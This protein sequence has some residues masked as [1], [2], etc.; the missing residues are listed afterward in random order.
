MHSPLHLP[1]AGRGRRLGPAAAALLSAALL[2][3]LLAAP[4]PHALAQ[5]GADP[6]VQAREAWRVKDRVR[7]AALRDAAL[8]AGQPLAMWV[9]YFDL[10]ARLADLQQPEFEA[11]AARWPGTYVE[12]R[13]RNDWLLELGKRR[14]WGNFRVEFP[15]FRMNDDREVSCY[16]MLLQHQDGQDVRSAAKA[17]WYAQRDADNGCQLLG[18]T[19]YDARVLNAADIWQEVRLSVEFNRPRAAAAAVALLDPAHA[20]RLDAVFKDPGRLLRTRRDAES[21]TSERFQVLALWRLA[22]SDPDAAFTQMEQHYAI[23]LSHAEA[24]HAWAGIAKQSALKLQ[25]RADDYARRAWRSWERSG[26]AGAAPPWSDDMLAW[27]ARAALRQG[28]DEPGRWSLVARAIDAMSPAEQRDPAWVYWRARARLALAR[29]GPEGEVERQAARSA[30]AS[31]ASPLT[32]YGLFAAEDLELRPA[33]PSAPAPLT[34]AELEA[35]RALPG[36]NRA[37][38]LIDLGLR[39]EGVRE[40]NYTLRGMGERELLATA[41][42]ACEREVW[43]RCINTSDRTRAEVDLAQRYPTPF[44]AQVTA[45]AREVGVDPAFVYGLIRQESRFIIDARSSVGASGLMQLM[46]ATA[47]WTAKKVGLDWRNELITDRDVNLLLGMSY[48]K[49]L[50]DEFGG[51]AVLATAAYNA[52]PGRPRRWRE[53]A[54]VEAAAWVEGIPFNETRDYVKKVVANAIVY[55]AVLGTPQLPPLKTRL[56]APIGPREPGAPAPD[57]DLP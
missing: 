33:L 10:N 2:A 56:G 26:P 29:P 31:I 14:D 5:N 21:P 16:A 42:W 47:R 8:A 18:Q 6:V 4:L 19:L 55:T 44:R 48:L 23:H 43:D 20:A 9:H 40:W 38:Q 25:P 49:L 17:A 57:R 13:L 27:H 7:L 15:R 30:L 35:P 50:L 34:R 54:V 22:A 24:A 28:A 53:G 45:R 32:F 1:A 51:S 41:Q 3:A 52:G 46:P 37:L 12:D 36:L 39:S 11:F